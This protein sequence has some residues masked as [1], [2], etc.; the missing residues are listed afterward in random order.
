M[1]ETLK[2]FFGA[3]FHQDWRDEYGTY[4]NAISSFGRSASIE[5]VH[6]VMANIDSIVE[7]GN[8]QNFDISR[9][10]GNYRMSADN[11]TPS[12]FLKE[13]IRIL[14][15]ILK[16]RDYC[17]QSEDCARAFFGACFDR[18]WRYVYD[19]TNDVIRS[20]A[21]ISSIRDIDLLVYFAECKLNPSKVNK[22][23]IREYDGYYEPIEDGLSNREFLNAMLEILLE[24]RSKK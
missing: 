5:Q 8:S 6:E 12:M 21:E 10:G 19:N 16:D 11:M 23:S 24:V 20:Y 4:E 13:V 18:N 15:G 2:Q 9:F 7:R 22:F 1:T 3:Y 17:K 14:S